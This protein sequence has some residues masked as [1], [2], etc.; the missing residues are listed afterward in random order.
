[1]PKQRETYE[2]MED[3]LEVL[4]T[5]EKT[6]PTKPEINISE[7]LFSKKLNSNTVKRYIIIWNKFLEFFQNES[8]RIELNDN[9]VKFGERK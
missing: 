4:H 2:I 9:V 5:L 8:R 7:F 3:I 1:M 6:N